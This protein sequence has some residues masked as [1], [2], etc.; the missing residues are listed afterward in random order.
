MLFRSSDGL[1]QIGEATSQDYSAWLAANSAS[2]EALCKQLEIVS[3]GGTLAAAPAKAAAKTEPPQSAP[4]P[5]PVTPITST[6]PPPVATQEPTPAPPPPSPVK[7]SS[8]VDHAL[9][10]LFREEV[11]SGYAVLNEGLVRVEQSGGDP[12]VIEPLMRAAHS[13]K[14][15]ARIVNLSS[16]VQLA[17][18]MEDCLVAAQN[19]QIRLNAADIDLLLQSADLLQSL[20]EGE[21]NQPSNDSEIARCIQHLSAVAKGES[22]APAAVPAAAPP[23][24]PAKATAALDRKST[25]LNSSH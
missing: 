9:L 16:I 11:R 23:P 24:A 8:P 21:A 14:G 13:I 5:T 17:H 2:I 25:R 1:Q 19:R 22:P 4:A 10:E 18:A 3:S 15:A 6:A 12:Q 20:A 7:T